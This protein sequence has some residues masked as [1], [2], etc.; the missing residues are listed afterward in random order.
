MDLFRFHLL[1]WAL[2]ELIVLWLAITLTTRVFFRRSPT[3]GWLMLPYLAWVTFAG[4]LNFAIWRLN[5]AELW[6]LSE[7]FATVGRLRLL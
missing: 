1:G 2:L 5:T 4:A 7:C 6:V 3:A